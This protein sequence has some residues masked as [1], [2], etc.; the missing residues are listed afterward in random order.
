MILWTAFIIGILGSFH[1]VG[2]CGPIVLA[3]PIGKSSKIRFIISRL[4]YNIGRTITYAIMGFIIGMIGETISM[5][6]YQSYLSIIAGILILIM[7]LIPTGLFNKVF[8]FS[9]FQKFS[10][11]IKIFWGKLFKDSRL[12]SLLLIGLL[13][14]F[15]PCGLVYMALAGAA[16]TGSALMGGLY[17]ILFGI[18]TIPILV[19]L[20]LFGKAVSGKAKRIFQRMIPVGGV[21]IAVLIILRGLSLGIPY[22][23][24]KIHVDQSGQ[25]KVECCHPSEGK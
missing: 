1:C 24:P 14:G 23:S 16:A 18:G 15:L 21:I 8:P 12:A 11:K 5:A 7:V 19:V 2:M 4:V 13:N 20:S 22:I 17:M 10:S 3:L 6:G 25:Q 9:P